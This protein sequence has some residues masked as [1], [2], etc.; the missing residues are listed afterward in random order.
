MQL[1]NL[2]TQKN[3][4]YA[5]IFI[6]MGLAIVIIDNTILN[7]SVPYILRDLKASFNDIEWVISGYTLTIA[8]VLITF[9]RL[10][11]LFG[12]KKIF[13]IGMFVFATGS[14][15]GSL[16]TDP[17]LLIFARAVIQALG[18]A[19]V[20]TSALSLLAANFMG[21]ERAIAF[22]L[23]GAIAGASASIG[24]LLGGYLTTYFSWRWSLRINLIVALIAI[25]GSI[26]I[27][28]SKGEQE[29]K[30]DWRG[31]FFSGLGLFCLVYAFIEGQKYGWFSAKQ[32]FSLFGIHWPFE[33][34]SVIPFIFLIALIFLTFFVRRELKLEKQ[35]GSPL[36]KMTL[37]KFF[38]FALGL[39]T[40]L[41]LSLGQ[42][43]FFFM[44]PIYFENVLGLNALGTGI[45]FLP[46]TLSVFVAG[47]L[48]GFIASKTRPKILVNLGMFLLG[49]GAFLLIP[50]IKSMATIW[51]LAPA[52]IIY[53]IGLGMG[54]AQL[55]NIVISAAP[56]RFAGEAS[57]ASATFR[58]VGA[59]IGV[60]IMGTVLAG[61]I[62]SNIQL[63]VQSDTLIPSDIK[64]T[65][66]LSLDKVNI[67]SGQINI[68]N[69]EIPQQ[70]QSPIKRDVD[71]AI[72]AASKKTLRVTTIF[73]FIGA[74]LSLFIPGKPKSESQDKHSLTA[75]N[76][77]ADS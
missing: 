75:N 63:N 32:S 53:G 39:F 23:W 24:P 27:I 4:W 72:M 67:E 70:L 49:L 19:M 35:G 8:T 43:G 58:Q 31:M 40:L 61:A 25:I 59:S 3:R 13:I 54:S 36:L 77:T 34:L 9:G 52:L 66:I 42:F 41:I 1:P 60:A 64:N 12:R 50:E 14:I 20:L 51:S 69:Q 76:V 55:T 37:F 18:A 57:A 30:F 45:I 26:F 28:E 68:S 71:D 15:L 7:V 17:M 33:G 10:A 22:G 47:I 2:A 5:L 29:K 6:A 11:D 16:A 65:V 48:S 56:N 21:R 73:I 62:I 44:T 46:A 74:I 38:G